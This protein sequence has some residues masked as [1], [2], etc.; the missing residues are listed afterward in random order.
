[1]QR[2]RIKESGHAVQY[3]QHGSDGKAEGM[4]H[5]QKVEHHIPRRKIDP[6][7]QLLKIGQDIGVG[8]YHAFGRAFGTGGE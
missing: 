7:F 4:E 8:Q 6:G 1:M 3:R 5:R 2:S